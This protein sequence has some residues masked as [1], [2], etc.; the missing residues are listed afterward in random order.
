MKIQTSKGDINI[1]RAIAKGM[2]AF[3]KTRINANDV[4]NHILGI[5]PKQC[6]AIVRVYDTASTEII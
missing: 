4:D 5:L 6:G 3:R 1:G 2:R